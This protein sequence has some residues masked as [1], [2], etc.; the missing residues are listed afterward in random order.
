MSARAIA[1]PLS[2]VVA[3][4]AIGLLPFAR[5]AGAQGAPREWEYRVFRLDPA[6]Y[7]DKADYREILRANNSD[8]LRAESDFHQ[9]VLTVLGREGWE[10]VQVERVRANLVF[11][12][13][14]RPAR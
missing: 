1:W 6:D 12:Y 8:P 10:L 2:L 11:F 9:H 5:P 13:L 7:N 4:A 14:K 3:V